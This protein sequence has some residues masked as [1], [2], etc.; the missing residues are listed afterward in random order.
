MLEI[1]RHRIKV[2]I[3]GLAR[4]REIFSFTQRGYGI[5]NALPKGVVEEGTLTTV[6]KHL[7]STGIIKAKRIEGRVLDKEAWYRWVLDAW[8]RCVGS[9][10]LF[11]GRIS[12]K[13]GGMLHCLSCSFR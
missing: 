9:K 4:R 11:L 7:L 6:K 8:H 13:N 3:G 12:G 2:R 10:G 1:K 5:W